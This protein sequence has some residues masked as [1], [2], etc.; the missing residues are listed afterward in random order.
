MK[1]QSKVRKF[2]DW[3]SNRNWRIDF[4]SWT[5]DGDKPM[6]KGIENPMGILSLLGVML[7][8]G[9]F[10]YL[11]VKRESVENLA[12]PVAVCAIGVILGAVGSILHEKVRKQSWISLDAECLDYETKLG[13]TSQNAHLWALRALCRF[14]MNG[15]E[16]QCTPEITWPKRKGE[17]WKS[18]YISDRAICTL[19]VN[20]KRPREVE[21]LRQKT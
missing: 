17:A 10:I 19:L 6:V 14:E 13:R 20:P 11:I 18:T 21:L 3:S 15:S 4:I 8:L 5:E 2:Q 12:L 7:F 16:I 1:V 9:G